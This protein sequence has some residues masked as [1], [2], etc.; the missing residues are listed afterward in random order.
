MVLNISN[1][2]NL[3]IDSKFYMKLTIDH[4]MD[5]MFWKISNL[6]ILFKNNPKK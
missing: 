6:H 2:E 5:Y 4:L 1:D 3:D